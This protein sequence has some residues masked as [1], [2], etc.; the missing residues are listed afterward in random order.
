[1]PTVTEYLEGRGV[2]FEVIPHDRAYT[3]IEEA[4]ALGVAAD[5]VLKTIVLN[6]EAGH[7]LAVIPASR[8]LDINSAQEAV[9]DK[10]AQFATEEEMERDF[11]DYELGAVP[12]LG[13]LTG[14]PT[15]VDP[16]VMG[17]ETV[18][19]AAGSQNQSVKV[20]TEDLFRDEP[21]TRVP[22]TKV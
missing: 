18:V 9:G 16:E 21:V 1:M 2:S 15:Y 5:E 12:P 20:R 13:S 10:H 22:L 4:R 8:R 11:P 7:A 6:T 14:A 19:F 3:S 17:H